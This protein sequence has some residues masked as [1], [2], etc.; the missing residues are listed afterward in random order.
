MIEII[1]LLILLLPIFPL[2]LLFI[3]SSDAQRRYGL[4]CLAFTLLLVFMWA[5]MLNWML[6]DSD[7]NLFS[8][9]SGSILNFLFRNRWAIAVYGL[10]IMIMGH[11]ANHYSLKKSNPKMSKA[12]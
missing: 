3:V 5:L 8:G 1:N 4:L 7:L 2:V 10:F 12:Q 11:F 6:L 9:W